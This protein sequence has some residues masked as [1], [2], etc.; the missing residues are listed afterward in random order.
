MP[1]TPPPRSPYIPT[2]P[3]S[4]ALTGN[5][6]GCR[7]VSPGC[8]VGEPAMFAMVVPGL[9]PLRVSATLCVGM[10][11]IVRVFQLLFRLVVSVKNIMCVRAL[12]R[13]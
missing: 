12:R 4:V 5:D 10:Y 13:S 11:G 1:P 3:P 7:S 2:P 6:M 9:E 8:Y